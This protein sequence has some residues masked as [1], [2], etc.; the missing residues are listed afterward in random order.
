MRHSAAID[1]GTWLFIVGAA[2]AV[3]SG[4]AGHVLQYRS[5]DRRPPLDGMEK[6]GAVS[7]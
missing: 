3:L 2:L 6:S 1:V 5:G 4:I 7:E